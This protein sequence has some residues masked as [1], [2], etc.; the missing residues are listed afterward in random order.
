MGNYSCD[1]CNIRIPHNRPIL[2][3]SLCRVHKHY[4]CNGLSKNQAR[5]I[6]SNKQMELWT[7]RDCRVNLFP[8]DTDLFPH[9]T[10]TPPDTLTRPLTSVVN[11]V[12]HSCSTCNKPCPSPQTAR[13]KICTW[14]DR[15]CHNKCFKNAL[16]CISCCNDIIPGFNGD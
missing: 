3:C 9:D 11:T 7:C 15:P 16:G 4:K 10:D 13:A 8:H 6:I 14:C 5:D 1:T 2:F 12:L